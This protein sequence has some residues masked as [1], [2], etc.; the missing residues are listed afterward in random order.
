MELKVIL[1]A[2]ILICES[3]RD[4]EQKQNLSHRDGKQYL[5][6]AAEV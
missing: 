1:K 2:K 6:L 5:L 4:T 3:S